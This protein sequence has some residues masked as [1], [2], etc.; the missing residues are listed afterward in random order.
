MQ[1]IAS[2][3]FPQIIIEGNKKW[4]FNPVLKKRLANR[5]EERVRL[6]WVEYLLHQSDWKKS[7]IGF[8]T[9]VKLRQE[10][11]SLRADLI[12]YS[13]D[14]TPQVLVEC[15][16]E[17]I[18]LTPK[19]AQ[20]AARYNVSVEAKNIALTNGV[21]D[22]WFSR[23][24]QQIL[25]QQGIFSEVTE[26]KKIRSEPGYWSKRGFC[27]TH[28]PGA[29]KSRLQRILPDFFEEKNGWNTRYLAFEDS[30]LD[31]PMDQ[32]YQIAVLNDQTRLAMSF[33]GSDQKPSYLIAVLNSKGQNKGVIVINLDSLLNDEPNTVTVY[34]DG[35]QTSVDPDSNKTEF[36]EAVE[37][38]IQNLPN[39][40]LKFFD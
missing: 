32:Y 29:V 18:S 2:Q 33:I 38:N 15:K 36:I 27:S 7:R 3:H 34:K 20:Q 6:R 25:E 28:S 22:F 12:L 35:V 4:L 23:N 26:L 30:L 13:N 9:P 40:L 24:N 19:V 1:S 11:N 8:E 14:L 17:K 39:R 10:S 31:L 5:P 16:S 37:E 21:K